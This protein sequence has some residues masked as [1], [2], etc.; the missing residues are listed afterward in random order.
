MGVYM[1]SK[2]LNMND[3]FLFP[4]SLLISIGEEDLRST[5]TSMVKVIPVLDT[6][7]SKNDFL[8]WFK[9]Q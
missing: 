6:V 5:E 3:L 2:T 9:S 1:A 7:S 8:I 4:F